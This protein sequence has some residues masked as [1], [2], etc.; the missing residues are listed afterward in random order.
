MS[1][2]IQQRVDLDGCQWTC[3]C[4]SS[5]Y[6]SDGRSFSSDMRKLAEWTKDHAPHTNG[7]IESRTS[8]D[9][10]RA[11]ATDP[12]VTTRPIPKEFQ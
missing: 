11:L 4:G 7:Q 9:G 10:M 6:T 2:P 5:M 3:P 12:G 1:K 8:A